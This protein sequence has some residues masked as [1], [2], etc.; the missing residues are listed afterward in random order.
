MTNLNHK[1]SNAAKPLEF[2]TIGVILGSWGLK[3]AVKVH[4]TTD[5][6]ERFKQG[7]EVYL[8]GQACV[9]ENSTWQKNEVILT[10]PHIDTPESASKLRN[11]TLEIPSS[12]LYELPEWQYYQF[13]IIGLD[14][15]TPNGS[16]I[17]KISDILNCGND[18]Y[19]VQSQSSKDILIPATK[20]II[21]NID[22]KNGR[23]TIEPIDGLLD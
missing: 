6:P 15:C 17:G 2:I 19:V 11:K 4:P 21:K 14:V 9:I 20:D 18:V 10:L 3:G 22:I 13:E 16:I 23:I 1:K 7:S 8:D 5:F 12:A